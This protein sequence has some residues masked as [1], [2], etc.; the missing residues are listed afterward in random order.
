MNRVPTMSLL[1]AGFALSLG[2]AAGAQTITYQPSTD[3]FAGGDNGSFVDTTGTLAV[4]YN[5]TD[6]DLLSPTVNGVT[7]VGSLAD[8]T[9]TGASGESI[10]LNGGGNNQG[11]LE[12]GPFTDTDV[13]GLIAGASFNITSV[14]LGGLTDG[15]EYLV[16]LI[17]NDARSSRAD[18]N[19]GVGDGSNVTAPI[20]FADLNNTNEIPSSTS[21]DSLIGTF[22]A[23]ASGS[24]TFNVF[25]ATSSNPDTF[26]AANS[27][28]NINAI[29][30]RAVPEPASLALL[31]LG[32]IAL[33]GRR[34]K[35]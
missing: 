20:A 28:S 2:T 25:G 26:I 22:T 14:T 24:V 10:T 23:D 5:A 35:A 8:N 33:I 9:V 15:Q 1:A 17:V 11:A 4:A 19:F 7:F 18:A 31:G 16:Q 32:G 3:L 34:K 13:V 21:G 6:A 12:G 29:Q 30:L 27:P